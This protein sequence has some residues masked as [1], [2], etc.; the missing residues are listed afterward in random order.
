MHWGMIT[1]YYLWRADPLCLCLSPHETPELL[2]LGR[3]TRQVLHAL[4]LQRLLYVLEVR[5]SAERSDTPPSPISSSTSSETSH[6]EKCHNEKSHDEKGG[7]R[8]RT[9]GT[10]CRLLVGESVG[11]WRLELGGSGA[12]GE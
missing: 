2:D 9:A 1:L 4:H 10:A 3:I 8:R 11:L 12:G 6:D 7:D 5:R